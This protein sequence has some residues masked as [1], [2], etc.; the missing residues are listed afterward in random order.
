MNM[1][2]LYIPR[3]SM[4]GYMVTHGLNRVKRTKEVRTFFMTFYMTLLRIALTERD[5]N[6][7]QQVMLSIGLNLVRLWFHRGKKCCNSTQ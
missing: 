5:K 2:R 6:D 3:L 7:S 4:L 1:C